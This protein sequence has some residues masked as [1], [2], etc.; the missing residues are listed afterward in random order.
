MAGSQ[1][2]KPQKMRNQKVAIHLCYLELYG[3]SVIEWKI[4]ASKEG[5]V[6]VGD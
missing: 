3:E 4:I 1:P 5:N 6:K 2:V